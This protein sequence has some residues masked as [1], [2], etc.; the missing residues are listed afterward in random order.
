MEI[1][2]MLRETMGT[3]YAE[4]ALYVIMGQIKTTTIKQHHTDIH[5][6][7]QSNTKKNMG[8]ARR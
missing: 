4:R 5:R 1:V 2:I 7:T 8:A 3:Q 6:A